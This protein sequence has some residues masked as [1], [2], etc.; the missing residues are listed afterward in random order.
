[1]RR[2]RIF[3]ILAFFLLIVLAGVLLVT[4][5]GFLPFTRS[6]QATPMP[7][8]PPVQVV[9]V[10]QNL[11]KG[12]RLTADV[13]GVIPWDQASITPAL[14]TEEELPGL[15]NRVTKYS[16]ESGTPVLESMLVTEG[17]Q[18]EMSGSS[19]AL[20]IPPG[21]VAVSIP[22]DRLSS[23]SYAPRSGDHVDVIGT[24]LVVDLDT[25]FQ[26][27][28]P[29]HTGVVIASGPPDPVSEQNNPLTV[30]I[31]SLLKESLKNAET[32][33]T[34]SPDPIPLGIY[35]KV[36]I[37]PVLGQPVYLVPSENQRPRMVSQMVLQNCIVLQ[38][39]DFPTEEELAVTATPVPQEQPTDQGQQIEEAAAPQR[40]IVI[41]LIVNPQDAIGLNY[42]IYSG[43][44]L[45]L[46]LRNPND[47]ERLNREAVTLQYLLE[48][49]QIPIPVRLPYGIHPRIDDLKL[50]TPPDQVQE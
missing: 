6:S 5:R 4:Q 20:N 2:G 9:V 13:L 33:E 39:G 37:D 28:L 31:A 45:T 15:I 12:Y 41:T 3:F 16:L 48:N 44:Q 1:M 8:A 29:N 26:S 24:M 18:V 27:I 21:S 32:G 25:D 43:A 46:T 14:F 11:P 40:P 10:T 23:V 22:I 30:Q 47:N 7:T 49:Y 38:I 50:P 36:V 34:T 35:G 42:M 17:E 19:W